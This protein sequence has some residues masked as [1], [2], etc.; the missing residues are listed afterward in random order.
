MPKIQRSHNFTIYI[1]IPGPPEPAQLDKKEII[2]RKE[3]VY[4]PP[5]IISHVI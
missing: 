4:H 1:R 5:H 2:K 3:F